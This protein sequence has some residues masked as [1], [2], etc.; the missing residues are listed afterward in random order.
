MNIF[1]RLLIKSEINQDSN[2]DNNSLL[3]ML[4]E[5]IKS[6]YP[7]FYFSLKEP[8][9]NIGIF[10]TSMDK[11]V[12]EYSNTSNFTETDGFSLLGFFEEEIRNFFRNHPFLLK[13]AIKSKI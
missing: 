5:K 8:N 13:N 7:N 4:V 11:L 1:K 6:N 12:Q 9:E 10:Y 2:N 3:K